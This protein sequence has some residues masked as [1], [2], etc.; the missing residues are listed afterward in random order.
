MSLQVRRTVA[1]IGKFGI[2]VSEPKTSKSRRKISLPTFVIVALEQHRL[3]QQTLRE[4]AGDKWREMDVVFSNIYGG[5][6]E[7]ANLHEAFKKILKEAELPDIRFHDLRHSAAT[8]LLGMGIHPKIVQELLGHSSISIT[9]D[10]Y[11]H[12]L[13]SIHREAMDKYGDIFGEQ[14]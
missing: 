2:V 9:L 13:P 7:A 3:Y 5:Y 11:S 10:T 8:I 4:K 1:R 12:V 14:P 6:M